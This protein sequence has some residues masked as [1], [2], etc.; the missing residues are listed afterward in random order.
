MTPEQTAERLALFR[1]RS[2]TRDQIADWYGID[3]QDEDTLRI[4]I[5]A[6]LFAGTVEHE[7]NLGDGPYDR[8]HLELFFQRRELVPLSIAAAEWAMSKEDF[9]AVSAAFNESDFAAFIGP[10]G[11]TKCIIRR[12]FLRDF[13][14]GF[15]S[16]RRSVFANHPAYI[17]RIHH[18][19]RTELHVPIT[20]IFDCTDQRLDEPDPRPGYRIDCLTLPTVYI[21][22]GREVP[23]ETGKPIEL[24]PDYCSC[25]T[26]FDHGTLL[27][28]SVLGIRPAVQE[29][30]D[31][32]SETI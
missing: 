26:L 1:S 17:Q 2:W 6:R 11:P 20:T 25:A 23:L 7:T 10:C 4:L 3:W 16:L 15:E 18:V 27:E 21:G 28:T 30:L 8:I 32:L 14:K 19:I 13:H 5:Q 29:V 12:S 31:R 9:C 22:L 24:A